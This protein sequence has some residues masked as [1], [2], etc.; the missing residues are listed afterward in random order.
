MFGQ[1]QLGFMNQMRFNQQGIGRFLSP[2]INAI[3]QDYQQDK[4][5]PYIQD[6]QNL[7]AQTFPEFD[8]RGEVGTPML[9]GGLLDFGQQRQTPGVT[10]DM[11]NPGLTVNPLPGPINQQPGQT[12]M[13]PPQQGLAG[14]IG[15]LGSL[16]GG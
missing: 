1:D 2:L 5:Q 15:G 14:R 4:V 8:M 13:T 6:V 12:P 10:G 7:T 11:Y 9:G 16:L 3:N